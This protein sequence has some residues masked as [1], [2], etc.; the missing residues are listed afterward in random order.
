VPAAR[1]ACLDGSGV[2]AALEGF[3]AGPG[4][5]VQEGPG[6]M[7]MGVLTCKPAPENGKQRKVVD[8]DVFVGV[9]VGV[10]VWR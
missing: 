3:L 4:G 2:Q 10:G 1:H 6:A 7:Q 8:I 5:W 9:G